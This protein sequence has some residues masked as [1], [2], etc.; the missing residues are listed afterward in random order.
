AV[1][2]EVPHH[3]PVGGGDRGTVVLRDQP[4]RR[5]LEVGSVVE[6]RSGIH[7]TS[8]VGRPVRPT[9]RGRPPPA[10]TLITGYH[11]CDH[12]H[13][14]KPRAVRNPGF[15]RPQTVQWARS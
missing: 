2:G 12:P 8:S 13:G 10:I 14:V 11:K 15:R 5:V 1:G 4:S 3:P 7:G 9:P 6:V